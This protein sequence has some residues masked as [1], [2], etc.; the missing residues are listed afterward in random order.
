MAELVRYS[1]ALDEDGNLVHIS[2]LT[3]ENRRE[4]RYFCLGCGAEMIPRL[5]KVRVKHFAHARGTEACGGETYL[6][7]LA[8][9]RFR[10]IFTSSDKYEIEYGRYCHCSRS[11]NCVF[12]IPEACI[13]EVPETFD[14]KKFYD[15]CEEEVQHDGFIADL[16][17]ADST[18]KY[19][20]PVMVEILVTHEC[21]EQKKDSGNRIIEIRISSEDDIEALATCH[22][23]ESSS[24]RFHGFNRTSSST[25][26]G[27]MR[28]VQRFV[29]FRS[30]AA[31]VPGLDDFQTCDKFDEKFSQ[32]S[33]FEMALESDYLGE[34]NTYDCGL[35][36]AMDEGYQ[37]RNC[38]LC[39]YY[40]SY[41]D[42]FDMQ[43]FCCMY[44]NYGTPR[45]PGQKDAAQCQYFSLDWKKISAVRE[46]LKDMPMQVLYKG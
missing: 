41:A 25:I 45:N 14:L 6:H 3:E 9:R 31:F 1:Y 15:T 26:D 44:K 43:P 34:I 16:L 46:V 17:L 4:H 27:G 5:G 20:S 40:K 7:S 39:R 32:K 22:L 33:V 29:L 21:T 24:V 11:G 10:E 18:G 12:E 38:I 23:T 37:P 42:S 13:A 30:G 35:V 2:S 8:K 19:M 36:K 28:Y